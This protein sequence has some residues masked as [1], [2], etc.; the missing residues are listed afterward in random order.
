QIK[1]FWKSG[2]GER[3]FIPRSSVVLIIQKITHR[4][5]DCCIVRRY[6]SQQA[7]QTP[8]RLRW[9]A[10]S[11]PDQL[12]IIVGHTRFTKTAIFVL[13]GT[14]PTDA[15][16]N[17]SIGFGVDGAERTKD[18][19]GSVDVIHS[20]PAIPGALGRLLSQEILNRALNSGMGSVP[21]K[22]TETLQ[23]ASS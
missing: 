8:R 2:A 9:G 14:Q 21:S 17:C 12:W 23:D 20:P 5:F 16:C 19:A 13:N 11:E 7:Q 15:P 3:V 10:H 1:H 18:T 6:Y 4:A 22:L